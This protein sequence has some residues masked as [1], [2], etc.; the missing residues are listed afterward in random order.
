MQLDVL[1]RMIIRHYAT[2]SG[3]ARCIPNFV[4]LLLRF[5]VLVC[6]TWKGCPDLI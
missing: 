6:G 5:L 2:Q 1:E 3:V 4:N